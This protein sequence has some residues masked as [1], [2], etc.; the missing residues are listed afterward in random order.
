MKNLD[1]SFELF[2]VLWNPYFASIG[3]IVV[4]EISLFHWEWRKA[5]S[6]HEIE[7]CGITMSF[8]GLK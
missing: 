2:T 8:G 3:F 5:S 4:N 7:I 6:I 1:V